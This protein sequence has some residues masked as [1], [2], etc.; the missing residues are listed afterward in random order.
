MDATAH[1]GQQTVARLILAVMAIGLSLIFLHQQRGHPAPKPVAW[2]GV[3]SQGETIGATTVRGQ[4]TNIDT[5]VTEHCT[6]G[7][8]FKLHWNASGNRFQQT[9]L[10]VT[11]T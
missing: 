5:H 10:D 6:D 3:T 2:S 4:L 11:G 8:V 9:G 1:R 7:S